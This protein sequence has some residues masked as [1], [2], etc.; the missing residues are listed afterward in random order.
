MIEA[1]YGLPIEPTAL[2]IIAHDDIYNGEV[3]LAS[4]ND[5][6]FGWQ[7]G[8]LYRD[9]K[10]HSV[11]STAT[12]SGALPLVFSDTDVR[13][14]NASYAVYGE[15][16]YAFT[17][18]LKAIAGLRYFSEH[19][20]SNIASVA[21]GTSSLDL[22]DKTFHSVN[23]RFNLS[24]AFTPHSMVYA[25]IAKGFRSGGFNVTSIG[26][27]IPPTYNSDT[28]W[29]YEVGTKH[30]LFDSRLI[31]DASVYRNQWS[32]VQSYTFVP[33]T[34]FAAVT[35]GGHVQGWGV[36]LAA[37]ARPTKA[38]TLTATYSWNNM[39]YTTTTIDKAAGDPVDGA[40]RK[41]W[42]ASLDYRPPLTETI[43]GVFRIDYQHAGPS[44]I[45]LR[46]FQVPPVVER[47]RRNLVNL[48]IGADIG[49]TEIAVFA[50]NLLNETAPSLIGPLGNISEDIEQRPRVIGVSLG[51]K[52]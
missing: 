7:L 9:A 48:R 49:S 8:A 52:F 6:P 26:E 50:D 16:S 29:T 46:N 12:V 41:S 1:I 28:I 23:P 15:L 24:Y 42:S 33:G 34:A 20:T 17:P 44:Q 3:R 19:K 47:P 18:K 21:L 38:L 32:G 25:N 10:I 43:S 11:S 51:T 30:E 5:G 40:V 35:N 4:K 31:L 13:Q 45:T 14:K 36:D 2:P 39:A 22:G 37:T 27:G